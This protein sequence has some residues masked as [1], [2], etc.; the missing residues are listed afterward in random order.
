M[1][2]EQTIVTLRSLICVKTNGY[3]R[4]GSHW[5]T[6]LC[7]V[8]LSCI[9]LIFLEWKASRPNIS[10]LIPEP[11][12]ATC[13]TQRSIVNNSTKQLAVS[14]LFNCIIIF[15]NTSMKTGSCFQDSDFITN[16]SVGLSLYQYLQVLGWLI[17]YNKTMLFDNLK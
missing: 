15:S 6:F 17:E 1:H 13:Q 9:N 10:S 16:I 4:F 12:L 14:Y 11:I 8:M 5:V 3:F 2:K 7:S